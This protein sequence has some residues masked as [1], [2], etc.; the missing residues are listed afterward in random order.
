MALKKSSQSI[1]LSWALKTSRTP[2]S[3]RKGQRYA[4]D[5]QILIFMAVSGSLGRTNKL[6]SGSDR[7]PLLWPWDL[8]SQMKVSLILIGCST[9][10]LGLI[11][12]ALSQ[13][14]FQHQ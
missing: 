14:L 4:L 13:H 7:R 8:L 3:K 9:I 11:L 12:K 6:L 10:N 5:I 2:F 1:Q